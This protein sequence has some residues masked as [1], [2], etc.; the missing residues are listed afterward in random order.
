M[1]EKFREN[2]QINMLSICISLF[3]ML[4]GFYF[5]VF[6]I[7][8]QAIFA[9]RIFILHSFGLIAANVI[10]QLI[11]KTPKSIITGTLS[12]VLLYFIVYYALNLLITYQQNGNFHYRGRTVIAEFATFSLTLFFSLFFSIAVYCFQ[13]F[14]KKRIERSLE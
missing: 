2:I 6:D 11:F 3:A 14:R 12:N 4:S 9:I 13:Y 7:Y 5:V 10:L 1:L 8:Y